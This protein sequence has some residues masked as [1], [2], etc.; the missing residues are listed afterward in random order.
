MNIFISVVS[1]RDT[2][3]VPTIKSVLENAENPD[4]LHFGVVSQDLEKSHPNLSFV[5]NLSYIKI[6]FTESRGVG[7]AR[8]LAMQLYNKESFYLQLDSHMRAAPK[9]DTK[10]KNMYEE[11]SLIENNNK[12]IL[13]QFPA[14]Y[15]IH[16]NGS[17][18]Y[19]KNHK[20]LWDIPSWSMVHNRDHGSWS[21][22]RQRIKDLSKPHPSHTVLAGYLF[23][24]GFFVRE[25]PYDERISFMGEE[26]CIALRAY[27]RN[28]KIYAPNEMLFWHF[29]KR[30]NSPKVWNQMDDIKRP[31]KWI[32]MEMESKRVQKDILL[33]N[34]RGMFGIKDYNKYIE[35]QEM[36]GIN[37]SDFYE[38]EINRKVNNSLKTEELFF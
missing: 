37:F 17:I 34:E 10:L 30:K 14:P 11:C 32:Q 12:I 23:A 2:E 27:T 33:A 19:P 35:Y 29:Y 7:H 38:N 16:T 28:W 15:E 20:E 24:P 18:F 25:I 4:D 31:L 13:S 21:A 6:D 5:R 1:Y 9:W 26:L 3:L 22:T 36:I 8:K